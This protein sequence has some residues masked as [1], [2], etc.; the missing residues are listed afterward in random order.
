MAVDL[1]ELAK[2]SD[3]Q[4][5]IAPL[6][7]VALELAKTLPQE[8][9]FIDV[10]TRAGGSAG[11]MMMAVHESQ[12]PR[13]VFTVD[14]HGG[15]VYRAGNEVVPRMYEEGLYKEAMKYLSQLAG[16]YNVHHC[17]WRLTS[18]DFMRIWPDIGFWYAGAEIPKTFGLVYLDGEHTEEAVSQEFSWFEPRLVEG[19]LVIVDDIRY[20][21]QK[22]NDVIKRL[23]DESQI[24]GDQFY[25]RKKA[26]A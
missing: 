14:P 24:V 5:K 23:W 25:W 21:R 16:E 17:H 18:Q 10:G 6:F 2:H 7:D 15:R 26:A 12:R 4:E 3:S 8:A 19:G 13:W 11:A 1:V 20:Y 9:I 22:E